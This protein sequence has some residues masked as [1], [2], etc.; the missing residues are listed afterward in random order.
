MPRSAPWDP[1]PRRRRPRRPD[2]RPAGVRRARA[3]RRRPSSR[4]IANACIPLPAG[5]E[6]FL[7][8]GREPLGGD[9][10]TGELCAVAGVTAVAA[11]LAPAHTQLLTPAYR[12]SDGA[13]R[14][15]LFAYTAVGWHRGRYYV[16]AV[17]VDADRRQDIGEFDQR[18]IARRAR[19][20][21]ARHRAN[22]LWQH[23]LGCALCSGCPAARNLVHG[24]LGG[25]AADLAVLQRALPRLPLPPARR[26]LLPG[27]PGADH[28]HADGRRDPRGRRAAP[29][30]RPRAVASFGQGCE[31]EPLLVAPL[32]E[33]AVRAIRAR[34]A[35][36]TLNLNTN[37]SRPA[38]LGRILDA[39]LDSVRV[40]LNSARPELYRA[41]ARPQGYG[42]EDVVESMRA[43]RRRGKFLSINYFV[44]PGVTDDPAEWAAF[45]RL[46]RE[47]RPDLIQWRNLNLDPAWYWETAQPFTGGAPLGVAA[48]LA[49][50]RREFPAIRFG[51]FN[52]P[53]ARAPAYGARAAR[54]DQARRPQ[55]LPR[56]RRP[57][58]ARRLVRP[59]P[60]ARLLRLR[61]AAGRGAALRPRALLRAPLQR[62]GDGQPPRLPA[63]R[64]G[65][66]AQRDAGLHLRRR[67]DAA[68]LS[69]TGRGRRDPVSRLGDVSATTVGERWGRHKIGAKSLEGTAAFFAAACL[70][71]FA[72]RASCTAPRRE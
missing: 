67:A 12:A 68:A 5:S 58:P 20:L 49:R 59:R 46:L 30:G 24:P 19:A 57:R 69:R 62:L 72:A 1:R 28:V 14:L 11:F 3:R 66:Q 65:A 47:V 32:I 61:G 10:R 34:T 18:E 40:S 60:P 70:A 29:R 43:V 15:P 48:I 45:R 71:G 56:A 39:G 2:R 36:G 17:R 35:R 25:A 42:F 53:A 16:P 63:P 54:D 27:D 6:L 13:P 38:A 4:W 52:P 26:L 51:Y 37:A 21:K 7:L 55:A 31:G 22:R 8:P 33:E 23:L 9:A 50:V 44:F 64:R 41:Y